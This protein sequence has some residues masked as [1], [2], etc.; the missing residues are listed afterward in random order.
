VVEDG[1][2]IELSKINGGLYQKL[3]KLQTMG[4]VE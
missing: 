3:I 1:S 4:D 2:H